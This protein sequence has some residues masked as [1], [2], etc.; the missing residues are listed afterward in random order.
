MIPTLTTDRL[1]LRAPAETDLDAE[2]EFYAS[3]RAIHV[4]GPLLREQVWRAL[5]SFIGHWHFRGYGFWGIEDRASGQYLGRAGLWNPEGWPEPEIGWA[6]M[7]GA[8]GR[9]IAF[10]AA[11]AARNHAYRTLG[12]ETAISLIDPDNARSIKLAERLGA[13]FERDFE[14]LRFGKTLIYRH[15][16][17]GA[18][19]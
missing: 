8:E 9:G 12:W 16:S 2:A 11:Q 1:I 15:P 7:A 13:V 4:G 5:A 18:V 10:E 3:D 19:Q 17:P 6:L 14:H